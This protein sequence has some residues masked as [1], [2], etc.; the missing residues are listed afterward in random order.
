MYLWCTI[1]SAFLECWWYSDDAFKW[2]MADALVPQRVAIRAKKVERNAVMVDMLMFWQVVK[3]W[4]IRLL[5]GSASNCGSTTTTVRQWPWTNI[6]HFHTLANCYFDHFLWFWLQTNGWSWKSHEIWAKK[7]GP[8][9]W[10]MYKHRHQ[11]ATVAVANQ[12]WGV[13]QGVKEKQCFEMAHQ[14][15]SR[16][17]LW[18]ILPILVLL[19]DFPNYNIHL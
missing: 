18:Q 17:W 5:P 4:K 2:Y 9:C 6:W 7:S 11:S 8:N 16:S 12:L 19:L 1:T 15:K 10:Q 14:C 3:T 13:L